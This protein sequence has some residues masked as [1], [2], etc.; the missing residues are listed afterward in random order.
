MAGGVGRATRPVDLNPVFGQPP[1]LPF[2][3]DHGTRVR[4]PRIDNVACQHNQVDPFGNGR[5]KDLLG[6]GQ[7]RI[8]QQVAKVVRDFSHTVKWAF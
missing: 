6:S 2:Q 7:R 1:K 8:E 5:L 3:K 4:P